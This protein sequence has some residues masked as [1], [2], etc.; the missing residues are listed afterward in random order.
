MKKLLFVVMSA[1]A[2]LAA[3]S[4]NTPKN[5]Y[6]GTWKP[7]DGGFESFVISYDSIIGINYDK[8][9]CLQCHYTLLSK[10]L[11]ALERCWMK[12]PDR[13]DYTAVVR[14]YY[15]GNYLIIEDYL[16]SLE[17]VYPSNYSN[18]ILTK[19]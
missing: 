19:K 6:E 17:Q 11:I 4:T 10:N 13:I 15:D 12:S 1:T 16:P 9:H 7:V 18:L 5:T 3:C 2:I 8:T 14:I